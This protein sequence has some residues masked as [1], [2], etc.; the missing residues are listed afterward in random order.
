MANRRMNNPLLYIPL[1]MVSASISIGQASQAVGDN[2]S[3]AIAPDAPAPAPAP[4]APAP[5]VEVSKEAPVA[6]P[7]VVCNGN[8]LTI[9]ANNSTLGSV[10]EAV[11]SCDGVK[12]DIPD[13]AG[14]S[15]VF[16]KLGPASARDVLTSLLSET[17]YD[18]VIGSSGSN[19]DKVE[20]VLLMARG[21]GTTAA[22]HADIP[23][24]P[25]RRAYLQ[26][27]PNVTVPGAAPTDYVPPEIRAAADAAATDNSAPAPA[28]NPA[29]NPNP[30][31]ASDPG[32]AVGGVSPLSSDRFNT[33][34]PVSDPNATTPS[35]VSDQ[36]TNMEKM[37][38]QRIQMNRNQNAQA[39]Q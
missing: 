18:F 17:G 12:I 19:P 3:K 2:A 23:M 24:T 7:N 21:A 35:N 22:L 20:T 8:Q 37:F 6:P 13:E 15:R 33:T 29:A 25:A 30:A 34:P 5:V 16:D 14:A 31:P 27:H 39:P 10:L 4:S 28:E 1:M 9:S 36:I 38:Q 11:R 32:A 26:M